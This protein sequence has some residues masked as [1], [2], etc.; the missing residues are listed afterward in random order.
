M[1]PFP[2]TAIVGLERAKR[3]LI[4]HAIDPRLGG[5]L[6]LGHRGCA[7]TTLARAFAALLP[8]DAPFVEVPLGAS[9]DR[10]LGSVDARGLLGEGKWNA[11]AGLLEQAHGG[12]LYVDEVNLLADSLADFLLDSA[13][14]GQHRMERDGLTRHVESRYILIGSM[15]PDEGDLRPQL[16]DRF[17]HGVRVADDFSAEERVEIVR[18]RMAFD[19]NPRG[20]SESFSE[21]ETALRSSIHAAC[22]RLNEIVFSREQRLAIA[23]RAR[24]WRLEGVRAELAVART[25]RCAAAFEN[26]GEV[27]DADIAEAW[28]LCLGHRDA[29]EPPPGRAAHNSGGLPEKKSSEPRATVPQFPRDAHAESRVVKAPKSDASSQLEAWWI[30]SRRRGERGDTVFHGASGAARGRIAWMESLIVSVAGDWRPGSR[31][32][33]VKF[34]KISQRPH[35]WFFLDASRSTGARDFLAHARDEISGLIARM[36]AC[37]ANLL[38]LRDG[39]AEWLGRN[40]SAAHLAKMLRGL[41][42]ASG[43]SFLAPA[44]KILHRAALRRGASARDRALICTDGLPTPGTG[45]TS[46][47]TASRFSASVRRL[48]ACLPL[49]WLH[50]T[51]AR[52]M[53]GWI[54]RVC[55]QAEVARFTPRAR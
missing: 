14:T 29:A 22:G 12:V 54:A 19:D 31:G 16:S 48:A 49:A 51:P 40:A 52:G 2:F 8:D 43:K 23:E 36:P 21:S 24:E 38:V 13:A 34:R 53:S 44:L 28:V 1:I 27:S 32:W 7:K 50:P 4:F 37:R 6:L 18:R 46:A 33:R 10:L 11:R 26:R 42:Y 41:T 17:A 45:E 20:F 30:S 25:A 3:S 35:A 5:S 15:N 55:G 47:M 39:H 9:E